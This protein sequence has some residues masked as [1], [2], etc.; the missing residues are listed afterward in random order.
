M[1]QDIQQYIQ[2]KGWE[3]K[4][5][6]KEWKIKICPYCQDAG[7]HFYISKDE[8]L[9]HCFKCGEKGNL[10]TL[11]KAQGDTSIVYKKPEPP[12]G[13][14]NQVENWHLNLSPK[15]REYLKTERFLTD[16]IIADFK[17][18]EYIDRQGLSWITFPYKVND[19][20]MYVK[21]KST[22][23]RK[24]D[25]RVFPTGKQKEVS[26][27]Y[28]GDILNTDHDKVVIT[29][30]ELDCLMLLT[31]GIPAISLPFGKGALS[32]LP[33]DKLNKQRNIYICLD[34]DGRKESETL[35]KMCEKV[36]K[37]DIYN[38]ILPDEIG[39]KG[40]ITDFFDKDGTF[41]DFF[42]KFSNRIELFDVIKLDDLAKKEIKEFPYLIDRLIPEGAITS[43]TADSGRGKSLIALIMAQAIATGGALFEEYR[44]K[45]KRVLIIDQEM[46]EDLI[47]GRIQSIF[48]GD[49]SDIFFLYEQFWQIDNESDYVWLKK[50][51]IKNDIGFLILDTFSTIHG[52]DENKTKDMGEITKLMLKLIVDTKVT[53]LYL[54]HHRKAQNGEGF[55]QASA[56]GSTVLINK[57][58]SHLLVNSVAKLDNDKSVIEMT[59]QQEKKRRP[60]FI[61]KIGVDII[62]DSVTKLTNWKYRGEIDSSGISEEI[63]NAI[64]IKLQMETNQTKKEI[65]EHLKDF[66][67]FD[68]I[69]KNIIYLEKEQKIMSTRKS[70]GKGQGSNEKR[71]F[72][73]E[74]EQIKGSLL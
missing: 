60:D 38:I 9:F 2:S 64:T 27:F 66:G 63:C 52:L 5:E 41:D 12:K 48:K 70:G 7:W 47:I 44:A 21:C 11:K 1:N 39:E 23:E 29:E 62:Y 31:N 25:F 24:K 20:W 45:K 58:G 46:D 32:K 37:S 36:E 15:I 72:L 61:N 30:G 13:F 53:V 43:L 35:C 17:I 6:N 19:K 74:N 56:R 73:A 33:I 16:E 28:N 68:T 65:A 67:K 69:N 18:G 34:N 50:Y 8:G 71:Y 10:L 42:G 51:I 57:V 49:S 14:D 40:D 54:H 26:A 22:P 3:H 4:P 59:I 55:S